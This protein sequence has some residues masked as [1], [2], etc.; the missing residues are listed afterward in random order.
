MQNN[1]NESN[2]NLRTPFNCILI[3][4]FYSFHLVFCVV[5][6][7]QLFLMAWI[8][9]KNKIS[10]LTPDND[11]AFLSYP[12]NSNL[13]DKIH[14]LLLL[15]VKCHHS[16]IVSSSSS[17]SKWW[18]WNNIILILLIWKMISRTKLLLLPLLLLYIIIFYRRNSYKNS[19]TAI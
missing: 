16:T 2:F 17:S 3:M 6:C 9:K 18:Q 11:N 8:Y 19:F 1:R 15:K 13:C 5:C 10:C 4:F 7:C 12:T 14:V